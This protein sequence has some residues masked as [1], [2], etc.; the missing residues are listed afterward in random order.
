MTLFNR[1]RVGLATLHVAGGGL[2]EELVHTKFSLIG[3]G[4][5]EVGRL[6]IGGSGIKTLL[7][8]HLPCEFN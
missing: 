5:G 6:H 1:H 3:H 7:Q 2:L 8:R 4:L